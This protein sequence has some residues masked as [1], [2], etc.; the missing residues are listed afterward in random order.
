MEQAGQ[1]R[2][3]QAGQMTRRSFLGKAAAASAAPMAAALMAPLPGAPQERRGMRFGLVT[4][5]WGK[6]MDLPTLIRSCEQSGLLGV[7]LRTDHKHG[8]EPTLSKAQRAEVRKRFADSPVVLVGYGSNAQFHENDPDKVR[9]NI[10]LTKDYVKLMADCGGTGVKVKPNGLVKGVP[11]EKTIEQIGKALNEVAA[12][13]EDFGQEIRVEA[14]GGGASELPVMKAIFDV[15]THRNATVCWNSNDVDLQGE[16]LEY[17]F[18]LVQ[19]RLGHTA[20]VRELDLGDYP[21]PKL[22]QLLL[23]MKYEGWIL[24]EARTAPKDPTAAMIQ[25]RKAFERLV[26]RT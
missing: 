26:G 16:G 18:R 23:D 6:D 1:M 25:Q 20:H 11:R 15:A 14:H 24:L 10:E 13:G 4:Y 8:V 7:E 21:Y 22:F 5:L 9:K 12:F 17:N 19:R 2:T 3:G